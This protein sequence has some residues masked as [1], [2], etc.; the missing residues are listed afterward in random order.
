MRGS[1]DGDDIPWFVRV[2]TR[3]QRPTGQ[4]QAPSEIWLSQ[5]DRPIGSGALHPQKLSIAEFRLERRADRH[6]SAIFNSVKR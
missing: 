3:E 2:L 1:Q 6:A 5:I 4:I